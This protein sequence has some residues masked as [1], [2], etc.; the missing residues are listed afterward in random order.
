MTRQRAEIDNGLS[1]YFFAELL[2]FVIFGIEIVS[3]L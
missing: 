1:T 2:P 3:A